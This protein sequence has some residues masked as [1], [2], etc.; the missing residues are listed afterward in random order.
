[1]RARRCYVRIVTPEELNNF[2]RPRRAWDLIDRESPDAANAD[3][4]QF[5]PELVRVVA[6]WL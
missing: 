6:L 4:T 3:N 5:E 1:M 2:A